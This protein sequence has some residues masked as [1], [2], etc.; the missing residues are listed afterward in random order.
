MLTPSRVGGIEVSVVV[1]VLDE[2]ESLAILYREL[3]A[4]LE[5][6]GRPY[7]VIFVDDGSRDGSFPALE[8]LHRND[9]RIRVMQLRRNFG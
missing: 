4:V 9:D 1:P 6:L 8:K 2:V 5:P 7:E 3:T